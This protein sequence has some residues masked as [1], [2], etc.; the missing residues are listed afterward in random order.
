MSLYTPESLRAPS[1]LPTSP[2]YTPTT[3]S[4]GSADVFGEITIPIDT[5]M[6]TPISMPSTGRG[7]PAFGRSGKKAIGNGYGDRWVILLIVVQGRRREGRRLVRK[8]KR[9]DDRKGRRQSANWLRFIPTRDGS[10]RHAA[11]QIASGSDGKPKSRRRSAIGQSTDVETR[12]GLSFFFLL[13]FPILPFLSLHIISS[14]NCTDHPISL[15]PLFNLSKRKEYKLI[16]HRRSKY[17]IRSSI[18]RRTLPLF[19]Y[20][21]SIQ[22][23]ITLNPPKS[24]KTNDRNVRYIQ[25]PP[26]TPFFLILYP[27]KFFSWYNSITPSPTILNLRNDGRWSLNT[28]WTWIIPRIYTTSITITCTCNSY[29]RARESTRCRTKWDITSC[30]SESISFNKWSE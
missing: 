5:G 10:D 9:A 26:F 17:N 18:K 11:Y 28:W 12:K 3:I 1:R 24:P 30:T 4:K 20:I 13:F 16:H 2:R 8:G 14:S 29:F 7:S 25:Y 6:N 22:N 19:L 27:S 23:L 15:I 21:R